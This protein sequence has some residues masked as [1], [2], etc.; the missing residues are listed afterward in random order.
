VRSLLVVT[1]AKARNQLPTIQALCVQAGITNESIAWAYKTT[2]PSVNAKGKKKQADPKSG[3]SPTDPYHELLTNRNLRYVPYKDSDKILGNTY[4]MLILQDFEAITPNILAR[5]VETVEGGGAIVILL[6]S[7]TELRQLVDLPMDIHS[8]FQTE[9]YPKAIPRFNRR[10][11]PSILSCSTCLVLNDQL[12]VVS[13]DILALEPTMIDRYTEPASETIT[14]F[15]KTADQERIIQDLL[16]ALSTGKKT[17]FAITAGR[18]RG[19]SATLGLTI[20]AVLS[21][22]P[23][24]FVTSP[25]PENL[26]TFF[27]F[28]VKGLLFKGLKEGTDFEITRA[29]SPLK[30]V[31]KITVFSPYKQVIQFIQPHQTNLLGQT[32]LLVI[33]EAAAI[34]LTL[35]KNLLGHYTVLMASTIHGYEGTGRSL[36]LKLIKELKQKSQSIKK[37][38]IKTPFIPVRELSLSQ[39]I[40]YAPGDPVEAW[41]NQL[42]CLD[43]S[44]STEETGGKPAFKPEECTVHLLNKDSLFS[45]T[46]K[47]EEYLQKVMA[48]FVE[49]HYKNSPNDLQLLSDAPAHYLFVLIG[50]NS[51]EPLCVAQIAL[52]GR[53]SKATVRNNLSKSQRADGDLIPW[54]V[55]QQFQ[56]EDFPTLLGARVVRIATNPNFM[57]QGYGVHMLKILAQFYNGTLFKQDSSVAFAKSN[58]LQ[59][60]LTPIF[61]I[62][63]VLL[64]YLGVSFGTTPQ[65][66]RFWKKAGFVPIYL[67]QTANELTGEHT[68]VM[69]KPLA[70][71]SSSDWLVEFATDFHRRFL[72]LLVHE[73]RN[74]TA[75][76]SLS[77]M[78]GEQ[79]FTQGLPR[80]A[81]AAF[82]DLEEL[83]T[84]SDMRRLEAYAN[85]LIDYPVV[86]DLV[87]VLARLYFMNRL[88]ED[89]T[90]S[91]VQRVILLGVGLQKKEIDVV[92][93]EL[94]LPASQTL[95]L[96]TK[97]VRSV[98][99]VL[100]CLP[101]E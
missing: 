13:G 65:L 6:E 14:K 53:I 74:F 69:I 15:A 46:P 29:S 67:K 83:L 72:N 5:T 25:G 91:S 9:A 54:L 34:P 68:C 66:N 8:K 19:K 31:L 89:L 63:P 85:N 99:V 79:L 62:Q 23:N 77:I 28:V 87:P 48:L 47:S 70:K 41:L 56:D 86:A 95:A 100:K 37:S 24:T 94:T 17:M 59:P 36:S 12:Q 10:F 32:D 71:S 30:S 60:L 57:G 44:V 55:A 39:P 3:P 84:R 21:Q 61:Q 42:L 35:V 11:V 58:D 43:A 78:E 81:L 33:D 50:P 73:F 2:N 4:G 101:L 64:D 90:L 26:K 80:R 22:Y 97:A 40:R 76:Q 18:G 98:V 1:G 7:L 82:G 49:S 45:F 93:E 51:E 16:E 75:L 88:P 20:S 96:F 38:K 52:E 92:S 27:Q